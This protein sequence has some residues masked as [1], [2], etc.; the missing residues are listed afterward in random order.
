MPRWKDLPEDLDPQIKEF[1][2]QL[3]R[4][5]DRSGLSIAALA[6]RTGYSKTSWERYLSGRLLAPKGAIVALSEVTGSSPVHLTTMWE[7]A[8]RAW[9]RAEMRHDRTMEAIRISQARA[10]LGDFGAAEATGGPSARQGGGSTTVTPGVAGPAG[11]SPSV[12]GRPAGPDTDTDTDARE[13]A[14]G[15]PAD[16]ADGEDGA[17]SGVNSWKLAGY[18]GPSPTSA[19]PGTGVRPPVPA[20]GPGP[21]PG[22]PVPGQAPHQGQ[23]GAPR[24]ADRASAGRPARR[25]RLT[26]SLAGLAGVLVVIAG[27]FWFM[28]QGGD[29]GKGRAAKSPA[30]SASAHVKLPPGVKC[31]GSACDGKDA[32]AMGCSGDLVTTAKTATVGTTTLEVR[33]SKSCGTVWGR[34]TGATQG[35]KVQVSSG[36]VK[37]TGEITAVGDAIA[38]TPMVAVKNPAA[39]KACAILASGRTGCTP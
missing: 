29:D 1:T 5:V 26:M 18:R 37:Q 25:Q 7:L 3:R 27:V 33:Y 30:P 11:V 38:Y 17:D 6:D 36:K 2:S 12:P 4:L 16:G 14:A 8:E 24:P 31:A 10:A 39:A 13:D 34:I 15:E 21:V 20:E 23:P 9:S 32:E 22:T 19:R 35:D 28:N